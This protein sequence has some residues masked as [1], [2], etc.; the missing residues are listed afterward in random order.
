ME[1]LL[2]GLAGQKVSA[3]V[4][5]GLAVVYFGY[6]KEIV[7]SLLAIEGLDPNV[8]ALIS[9]LLGMLALGGFIFFASGR[10]KDGSKELE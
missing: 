2:Q 5:G 10:T 7:E 8:K 1:K 9:S 3:V 4:G 6:A